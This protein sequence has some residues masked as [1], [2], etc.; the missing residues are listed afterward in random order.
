M[1]WRE[2][3]LLTIAAWLRIVF[4]EGPRQVL[5]ALTLYSVLNAKLIPVGH[6]APKDGHTPVVQFFVNISI[7]AGQNKQQAVVL[8]GMLYTLVIWVFSALSLILAVLFYLLFLW[9]H[10]PSADGGLTKYC[11]RKIEKRLHKI[12]MATVNKALDKQDKKRAVNDLAKPGFLGTATSDVKRQPTLPNMDDESLSLSRRTT[13]SD[14]VPFAPRPL[15]GSGIERAPS[16]LQ[17]PMLPDLNT[18]AQRPVIP[19]R[20]T[21]QS[22]IN[23]I[24]SRGSNAPLLGS[25]APPGFG[26]Y[27]PSDSATANRRPPPSRAPSGFSARSHDTYSSQPPRM[28]PPRRQ[29]TDMSGVSSQ[30]GFASRS[31]SRPG[32]PRDHSIGSGPPR[33]TQPAFSQAGRP[34][35]EFEMRPPRSASAMSNRTAPQPGGPPKPFTPYRPYQPR[36]PTAP[37][38]R[39]FTSPQRSYIGPASGVPDRSG[40][41]PLPE[42][43]GYHESIIDAYGGGDSRPQPPPARPATAGPGPTYTAYRG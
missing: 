27:P 36:P 30:S 32:T 18:P 2:R 5:N 38:I 33:S 31:Q 12:V 23:S 13:Q 17:T 7:L 26:G 22:S 19:S 9:H 29:N 41:A 1:R 14:F 8:F 37:P 24:A 21:T 11:K 43:S 42:P 4:A 40:T 6:N 16:P 20:Q 15:P 3:N 25:A 35:Q 39:N 28:G 34:S 10:I